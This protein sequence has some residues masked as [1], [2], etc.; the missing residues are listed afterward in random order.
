MRFDRIFLL[1]QKKRMHS[2]CIWIGKKEY[3]CRVKA[4]LRI[5]VKYS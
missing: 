1:E 3:A 4:L 5:L 2:S